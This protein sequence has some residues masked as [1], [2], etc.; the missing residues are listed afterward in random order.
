MSTARRRRLLTRALPVLLSITALAV[1]L[2]ALLRPAAGV[3]DAS[4]GPLVAQPDL[5]P[6]SG[7]TMIGASPGEQAD[8]AWGFLADDARVMRYTDAGGWEAVAAPTDADGQPLVGLQLVAGDTTPSGGVTLEGQATVGGSATQ[9][10]IVRDP[11]G[12]LREAPIPALEDDADPPSAANA[13]LEPGESLYGADR[14][15][16]ATA[17]DEPSG[18]TGALIVPMLTSQSGEQDGVLH[19]DGSRW[20]REPICLQPAQADPCE[21]PRAGFK[22]VAIAASSSR[23]AWL[24]VH[25]GNALDGIVLFERDMSRSS[26][27]WR[28]QSLDGSPFGQSAPA[29]PGSRLSVRIAAR[30]VGEPLTVTDRGVWADAQVTPQGMASTDATVYY[31]IAQRQIT[32]SWCDVPA[33]LAALCSHPL[34]SDLGR[35]HSFAWPDGEPYGQRVVTGVGAGALLRLDGSGFTR[36]PTVGGDAGEDGAALSAPDAGWLSS[37]GGPVHLT[38]TPESDL[39]QSWPVPFRRPLTAIVPQPGAAVGAAGSQALAVGDAGEVARYT[40][41]VGWQ[42]EFL[43]AA[44]GARATPRLRGVAWPSAGRAYAVG[45]NAEMW[46]W[47]RETGLWE[48]DPGKPNAL[49]RANFTG[50][51]FDPSDPDRGYAIGKQGVLLSYGRQWTQE[52]LPDGLTGQANFTSIAF[53]GDEALVSYKIPGPTAGSYTGGVIVNDGAGWRIDESIAAALRP[54]ASAPQLVAGLPDGGAIVAGPKLLLTRDHAGAAWVPE[55]GRAEF[56]VALAAIRDDGQLRAVMS[57]EAATSGRSSQTD[58]WNVDAEEVFNQPPPGQPPLLTDPYGLPYTGFVV[59]QTATGWH[60]EQHEA[61]PR[62]S[63]RDAAVL[64]DAVLALSLNDDGSQGWAVGGATGS[65]AGLG[66]DPGALQTAGVMRYP[67]D[68]TPPMGAGRAPVSTIAGSTTIAIGG[69]AGCVSACADMAHVGIG[70]ETWLPDAVRTASQIPAV[71]AFVYTGPGIADGIPAGDQG[72]ERAAYASRLA[73]GAGGL[74]VF[75]AASASDLDTNGTLDGFARAFSSFGS[76]LGSESTAP[77]VTSLSPVGPGRGY[78]AFAVTA[79]DGVDDGQSGDQVR[80]IV[81]D[82]SRPTLDAAQQCWLAEQ[83]AGAKAVGRPA[84]VIGQRDL[85]VQPDGRDNGAADGA[86]TASLLLGGSP[87]PDC[88]PVA[89]GSA[90]AY[91]FDYPEMNRSYPITAGGRSIPSFGSGTLGYVTP[92]MPSQ[93]DFVG[94]S[95]FLVAQV[96]VARRDPSSNIAPVSALLIPAIDNLAIDATDGT[97]LRRSQV[98]LF[99]ALARRPDAGMECGPDGCT[100]P[101]PYVPIPSHC[102]GAVCA[103]SLFPE[104]SFSSSNPDIADF[105]KSDPNSPN[106]RTVLLGPDDKAIPDATSGLLCAYN[107]GSTTVTVNAGGLSYSMPVTVQPGS[108]QRP[109]GTVPLKNPPTRTGGGAADAPP[110]PAFDEPPVTDDEPPL[111]STPIVPPAQ[112]HQ[113]QP[114]AAQPQPHPRRTPKPRREPRPEIPP[115]LAAGFISAPL[116]LTQVPKILPPPPPATAQPT[117]PSG[118][119][120]VQVSQPAVSPQKQREEEEAVDVVHNYVA[121]RPAA[122]RQ[123]P[124]PAYALA[125]V[126]LAAAAGAGIGSQRRNRKPQLA[127]AGRRRERRPG[128]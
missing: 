87:P 103:T 128:R 109:C 53:A 60:D 13:V 16:L 70:P 79:G 41:G 123:A 30:S 5:G 111:R 81:L 44:N 62:S 2:A 57:V 58:A 126:L 25:S 54:G 10:L 48:P 82:Y 91:F 45:D 23:N 52:Q 29:I 36:V 78:Y 19:F 86:A 92:P 71:R 88:Q 119:S 50:I 55:T 6:P 27:V 112:P 113:E 59:R 22:V 98:A 90:S 110:P 42:P 56:P 11:G 18:K 118:T 108:V 114:P 12:A 80:V 102:R 122:R 74:P 97:L 84:I 105:V 106:P 94:A 127:H 40:P 31:D 1:A 125:L 38:R 49:S 63:L 66:V 83:L 95:G 104:Y 14:N 3:G 99:E 116:T 65:G 73:A 20:S 17:I 124:V 28:R 121:Y 24:L 76:P 100:K 4:A 67:T 77:G 93:T 47:R 8:E 21:A 120:S 34:G 101:D 96:D 26:P 32:G 85:S 51:A 9:T 72:R 37:S 107:A 35:G 89:P 15:P 115:A 43:I 68:N 46:L 64:P 117:P 61:Y 69:G 7:T 75:A 39:L 33:G